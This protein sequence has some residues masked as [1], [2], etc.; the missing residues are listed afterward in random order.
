M[1][2]CLTLAFFE[3][4]TN[5]ITKDT[6]LCF[7]LDQFLLSFTF[8]TTKILVSFP[9]SSLWQLTVIKGGSAT[10]LQVVVDQDR[11][12]VNDLDTEDKL[13]LK[14]KYEMELGTIVIL[15]NNLAAANK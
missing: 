13:V 15:T 8:S 2:R 1:V 14:D 3:F 12:D 5:Y 7:N 9:C 10:V 11:V 6:S 4:V